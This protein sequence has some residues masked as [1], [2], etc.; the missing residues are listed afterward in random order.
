M[1]SWLNRGKG[2]KPRSEYEPLERTPFVTRYHSIETKRGLVDELDRLTSLIVRK[3]LGDCCIVCGSTE[4]ITNGHL[5]SRKIHATRFDIHPEGNCQPQCWRDNQA[6]QFNKDPYTFAFVNKYGSEAFATLRDR[7]YS[8]KRFETF[9]LRELVDE[10][11]MI[12]RKV[13]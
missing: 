11:R 12:L 1:T 2:F 9:E 8:G 13:S 6:H 4:E 7:A 3:T 10:Y 5:F